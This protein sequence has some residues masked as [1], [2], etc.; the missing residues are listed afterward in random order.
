MLMYMFVIDAKPSPCREDYRELSDAICHIWVVANDE[1]IARQK[2]ETYITSYGWIPLA[3]EY[4]F[5]IQSEHP[6]ELH[7]D[8]ERL[9]HQ[10]LRFGV[11]ADFLSSSKSL[12]PGQYPMR[13]NSDP[14]N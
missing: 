9:F 1:E 11:A 3:Y 8:E 7:E 10:A 6:P 4:A 12:L 2:A 13:R 14:L 5:E